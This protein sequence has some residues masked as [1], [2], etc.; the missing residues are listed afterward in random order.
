MSERRY[1]VLVVS[2]HPIQYAAPVF[3]EMA[4]HPKMEVLVAYCSMQGVA[5]TM[6]PDFGVEVVWD[7]PLLDGYPWIH[8]QNRSLR[9]GLGRFF[10]LV[11]PGLWKMIRKGAF[12][13]IVLLTGYVYA[14][15]WI[16]L[17]AAKSRKVPVLF[18]TDAH[19]ITSRDG[20]AWKTSIKKWLWP[21]LF[22]LAD[23]VLVASTGGVNLMRS[24]GIPKER[25]VLTS[26]VVDNNWWLD[27]SA[28]VNRA[29]VRAAW[30]VPQDAPVVLF[31]G[32]LQPWKRPQ[33]L[34]H[35]FARAGVERSY[36]IFAGDGPLRPILEAEAVSLGVSDRVRFLGF[37]NQLRLPD[38]YSSSSILV[39][40]SQYEAFGLVVNEAML[41]GCPAIVSDHV[42]AKFDLVRQGETGFV[43]PVGDIA[44]LAAILREMLPARKRLIQMSNAARERM[45]PWSP[46]KNVEGI[47]EAVERALR[48][49]KNSRGGNAF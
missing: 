29:V 39:L 11:N 7:V 16:A 43:F 35:A 49:R 24:L 2:S 12:D 15:F 47:V 28:R 1:R 45:R 33:D 8:V 22:N 17:A 30:G 13:A 32:K 46:P 10:G 38:A 9:P 18:G 3:R 27:H 20:K 37:I 42:G 6:D 44:A 19:E 25:V 21:H 5:R 31:C 48:C 40:P 41:C 4:A 36:L 23:V 26:N 34:L 14:S